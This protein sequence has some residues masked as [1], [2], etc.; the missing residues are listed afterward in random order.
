MALGS[1]HD[2]SVT[3]DEAHACI[4]TLNTHFAQDGLRWHAASAKQWLLRVPNKLNVQTVDP[5]AGEHMPARFVP[6]Q[7]EH[8]RQLR[9]W[10]TE[11]QMLLYNHPINE[12]RQARGERAINSVWMWAVGSALPA[13][14]GEV[15][16]VS[17]CKQTNLLRKSLKIPE[18]APQVL[19]YFP[20]VMGAFA[21]GDS[22]RWRTEIEALFKGELASRLKNAQSIDLVLGGQRPHVRVPLTTHTGMR[23]WLNTL[24]S[25]S[26]EIGK[27]F[28]DLAAL[29]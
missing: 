6:M 14:L 17:S 11:A 10:T 8:A 4:T 19:G 20:N 16:L 3:D 5:W 28:A 12:A 29:Q 23:G 1:L 18:I 24:F 7:G 25:N 9:K 13:A 15:A 27:T 21:E 2:F 26:A 22:Q